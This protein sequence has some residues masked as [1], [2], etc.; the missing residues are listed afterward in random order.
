VLSSATFSCQLYH[1]HFEPHSLCLRCYSTLRDCWS[2]PYSTVQLLSRYVL[3]LSL[4]S[5]QDSGV[6]LRQAS[7][8]LYQ[9][10]AG[11]SLPVRPCL[12]V[13][14]F[15]TT[16]HQSAIVPKAQS[17]FRLATCA[18]ATLPLL[19]LLAQCFLF[20][21]CGSFSVKRFKHGRSE[22]SRTWTRTV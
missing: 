16:V 11:S 10:A 18:K 14:Q 4:D 21:W 12:H 22:K 1:T 15:V 20:I 17:V 5:W 19:S 6:S 7:L 13:I 8:L 2:Q 3:S 9:S